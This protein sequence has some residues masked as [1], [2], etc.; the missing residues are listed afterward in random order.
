MKIIKSENV[1]LLARAHGYFPAAF[2]WRGR[3]F[4]VVTVEKC[5]T[6]PGPK[7]RRIFR[8]HCDAGC[9][10]LEQCLASDAWRVSRWPLAFLWPQPRRVRPARFPLPRSQRRPAR[11]AAVSQPRPLAAQAVA[12]PRPERRAEWMPATQRP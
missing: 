7:P 9:F 2:R 1:S 10:T 3:R 11:P 12:R 4:D 8:V 6:A 5:W